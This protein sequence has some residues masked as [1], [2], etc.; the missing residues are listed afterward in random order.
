[1][2][3]NSSAVATDLCTPPVRSERGAKRTPAQHVL[4]L[5]L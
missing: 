2:A 1:M 5:D 4:H 3:D